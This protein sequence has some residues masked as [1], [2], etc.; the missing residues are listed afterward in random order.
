VSAAPA[1]TDDYL[2]LDDEAL[3]AQCAVERTRGSGPGGQHRNKVETG[4]R[5]THVPTGTVAQAFERRSQEQ[6]RAVALRRLRQAIALEVRRPVDLQRMQ[7]PLALAAILPGAPGGTV[8]PGNPR[9]WEGAQHLLDLFLALRCSVA[10]TAAVLGI[11]TGALSRLFTRDP[12]LMAATN[13]YREKA[14][15]APLRR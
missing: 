4:I 15:L 11:S 12:D 3:L 13:R 10:D 14:G 8:G 5:L 1:P 9:F 7:L 2:A 6:N